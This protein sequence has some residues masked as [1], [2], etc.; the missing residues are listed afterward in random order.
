MWVVAITRV[1]RIQTRPHCSSMERELHSSNQQI[2]M[3]AVFHIV[4]TSMVNYLPYYFFYP[5]PNSIE[6]LVE[7]AFER[8]SAF[9]AIASSPVRKWAMYNIAKFVFGVFYHA[10]RAALVGRVT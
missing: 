10:M 9:W 5:A 1:L 8:V 4:K 3:A 6:N 7:P 2:V